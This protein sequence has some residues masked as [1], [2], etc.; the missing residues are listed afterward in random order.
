MFK[1]T[2]KTKPQNAKEKT[3]MDSAMYERKKKNNSNTV[4][5]LRPVK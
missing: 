2:F 1:Q 5:H 4:V 3:F